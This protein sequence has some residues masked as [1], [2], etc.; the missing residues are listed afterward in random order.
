MEAVVIA[1]PALRCGVANTAKSHARALAFKLSFSP[2]IEFDGLFYIHWHPNFAW[3]HRNWTMELQHLKG[4]RKCWVLH[5]YA[6]VMPESVEDNDIFVV[7][8]EN[9]KI[10]KDNIVIPMPLLDPYPFKPRTEPDPDCVGLFGFFHPDKGFWTVAAYAKQHKKKARFVTTLHPFAPEHVRAEFDEFK[11]MCKRN[12]FDVIDDWLEGQELA[13][14]LGVC[15]FFLVVD[16]RAVGS[17]GSITSMLATGRPVFANKKF[18]FLGN[19]G[20]FVMTFSFDRWPTESELE[21]GRLFALRANEELAPERIFGRL[22][23]EVIFKLMQA[24]EVE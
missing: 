10:R 6:F 16:R 15:G 1:N 22:H 9:A 12:S 2:K 21:E 4:K 8:N 14:A 7:F 23:E 18:D 5:D 11:A 3:Q 24:R 19:A 17:S 20:S 13:D